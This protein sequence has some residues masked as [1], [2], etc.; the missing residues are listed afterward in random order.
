MLTVLLLTG[1]TDPST[2]G[3]FRATPITNIILDTLGVVDEEPELFAGARDPESRDLIVNEKEYVIHSGD[4]ISIAILDLFQ[5]GMEWA[6]RRQVSETGRI[7]LPEIGTF[8]VTGRTELELADDIKDLLSPHILKDPT[9]NI[10]VI[11]STSK[12]YSI[13]GAIAGAGRY[14]LSEPDFRLL[15]ALAQAGGPPTR[16]VDF[17]YVLRTLSEE[18]MTTD[19]EATT[20]GTALMEQSVPNPP[21]VTEAQN[22]LKNL[23]ESSTPEYFL[24]EQKPDNVWQPPWFEFTPETEETATPLLEETDPDLDKDIDTESPEDLLP[25]DDDKNKL[26]NI[27]LNQNNP[28]TEQDTHIDKE[29]ERL[30][31]LESITPMAVMVKPERTNIAGNNRYGYHGLVTTHKDKLNNTYS[32]FTPDI[33]LTMDIAQPVKPLKVIRKGGRFHLVPAEGEGVELEEPLLPT[34]ESRIAPPLPPQPGTPALPPRQTR[35]TMAAAAP[36]QEVIRIDLKALRQGDLSQNIVI[37]PGDYIHLE[38]NRVGVFY[39]Q[40]QV[41]RPGPYSLSGERMTLKEA[42]AAAGPITGLASPSRCDITRRLGRDKSGNFKEVTVRINLQKLLEGSQPNLFIKPN[43]II[44]V[45]SHP[46]ARFVAVI[47][48]S[49][50]STYGFGFVYD[51]NFADKDFGH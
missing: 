33:M 34:P 19:Q 23:R 32:L 13:S 31:L 18:D 41:A 5:S 11:G 2:I 25:W 8:K 38:Y 49:F 7:T 24:Q 48:N 35:E 28:E 44:N 27:E 20:S 42:I 50:R 4:V 29:Q 36:Y 15:E 3:R 9:V 40:G 1:C 6:D 47:R 21:Q 26:L 10:V 17:A 22:N 14:P 30:G 45:G 12:V 39:V 16:G 51:R 37:R 46:V 43:D